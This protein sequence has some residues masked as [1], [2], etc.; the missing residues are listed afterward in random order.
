M[1]LRIPRPISIL[2]LLVLLSVCTTGCGLGVGTGWGVLHKSL[3]ITP[4]YQPTCTNVHPF[5]PREHWCDPNYKA[6]S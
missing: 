2:T 4:T 1:N 6:G 5:T 3:G